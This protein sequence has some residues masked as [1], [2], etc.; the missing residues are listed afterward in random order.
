MT[1]TVIRIM[2]KMPTANRDPTRAIKCIG[3]QSDGNVP[4]PDLDPE[5]CIPEDLIGTPPRL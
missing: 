4:D 1:N 3:V 5:F 2:Q